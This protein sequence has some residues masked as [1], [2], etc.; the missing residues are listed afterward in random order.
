LSYNPKLKIDFAQRPGPNVLFIPAL[1]RSPSG[2][3]L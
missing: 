1:L 2:I 3:Y